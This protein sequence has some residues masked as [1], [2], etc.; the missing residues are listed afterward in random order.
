MFPRKNN[1]IE[2]KKQTPRITVLTL[3]LSLSLLIDIIFQNDLWDG[4]TPQ[5]REKE[6]TSGWDDGVKSLLASRLRSN[7]RA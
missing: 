3:S 7:P 2:E 5:K 6:L 4:E 1:K